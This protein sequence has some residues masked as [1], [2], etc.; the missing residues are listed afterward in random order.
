MSQPRI[1]IDAPAGAFVPH[2]PIAFS[3][4]VDDFGSGIAAIQFSLDGGRHW[5]DYPV[6]DIIDDA[7]VSWS[8]LFTPTRCGVHCLQIRSID[9]KGEPASIVSSVPFEVV[10]R[11]AEGT[12]RIGGDRLQTDAS[13]SA[14]SLSECLYAGEGIRLR[15]LGGAPLEGACVFRSEQLAKATEADA[16]VIQRLG[17]RTI[18]D[19]RTNEEVMHAPEPLIAGVC[20]V[21]L[22]PE[23]RKRRKDASKR[24]VAGVIGEYGGPEERMR[25]NYRRYVQE[26]PLLGKALR[27]M[28]DLQ[29]PCLVHCVNGKDRTGVLCATLQRI[30]GIPEERIYEDYLSYNIL[31]ADLIEAEA[32]QLGAGMTDRERVILLSFLE[33][34]ESYLD[35]FFSEIVR[36]FGSFEEYVA[37][38]LRLSESQVRALARLVK[39]MRRRS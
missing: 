35:A 38:H 36:S 13:L 21:A 10:D 19:I 34:R 15:A 26:Y 4:Y 17:I 28:A 12:V 39:D 9:D 11:A 32:A 24:L 29:T 22:V 20:T 18:Y 7:G 16:A 14:A 33:A 23:E 6:E 27:S 31:N 3:G 5:T 2:A 1:A 25:A 37:S 8:F 30:A